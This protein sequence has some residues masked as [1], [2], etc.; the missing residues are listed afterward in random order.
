MRI[1]LA[2]LHYH[3]PPAPSTTARACLNALTAHGKV[4]V[5]F[6][7]RWCVVGVQHVSPLTWGAKTPTGDRPA[8][9]PD[10]TIVRCVAEGGGESPQ[11]YRSALIRAHND[12]WRAHGRL[13]RAPAQART[14]RKSRN[15]RPR[16]R[17]IARPT[18]AFM[19]IHVRSGAVGR[20]M[21]KD[22]VRSDQTRPRNDAGTSPTLTGQGIPP[23]AA[24]LRSSAPRRARCARAAPARSA[25]CRAFL[26]LLFE[27]CHRTSRISQQPCQQA[28]LRLAAER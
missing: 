21:Q 18:R 27:R 8:P 3:A 16:P 15:S 25:A 24:A 10:R 9:S 13:T 19:H 5:G 12:A 14:R 28:Q 4:R 23:R 20:H 26:K 17:D 6:A 7:R 1:L 2:G 22:S 11:A